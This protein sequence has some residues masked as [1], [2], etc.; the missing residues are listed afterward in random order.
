MWLNHKW[1]L[2]LNCWRTVSVEVFFSMWLNLP[3]IEEKRRRIWFQL[4]YSSLCDWIT[5]GGLDHVAGDEFQL[6]YSSLC[7]WICDKM[8]SSLD[9]ESFSW[10]IL[11]YVIESANGAIEEWPACR[12]SWSILLYV[13]ESTGGAAK[14][15]AHRVSVEVFF[16][17][18]LNHWAGR[19]VQ[20]SLLCFSWSILLY[21]IESC[22][23][24]NFHTRLQCFSW[25]ILLYVI[26]SRF[27]CAYLSMQVGFS[28]SILLYVIESLQFVKDG[29]RLR[30]QLKY[31]SLCDWI[32]LLA[33]SVSVAGV[34]VEVFFSMWLNRKSP[35][36]RLP[37]HPFQL[38]YSS[39]C[40]W[41][42]GEKSMTRI[43]TK[44]QLKYSSLCDWIF[45][46][47]FSRPVRPVSV[48]VFF[49]MWL[50]R[51]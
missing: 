34:S 6:K 44:F 24:E 33:E 7:D 2:E 35:C 17:M 22:Y 19:C 28:W 27:A 37:V 12:F 45:W 49:S 39:L 36:S 16:S 32:Q 47:G 21:V 3:N 10:S 18:W 31:S 50:N 40:D 13:I 15:I 1:D 43:A 9:K 8:L 29:D 11:L 30:F 48:E 42:K 51:N 38:K 5:D 23:G 25:S 26:E 4:K 20:E 41:I 46:A 14:T